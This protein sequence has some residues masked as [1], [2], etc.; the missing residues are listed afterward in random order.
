L[1]RAY[2]I[3]L[4]ELDLKVPMLDPIKCISRVANK[5]NISERTKRRAMD[6]IHDV[7]KSG[8]ATGKDPMGLAASVLYLAC[9]NSGELKSQAAIAEAAGVSEV[10]L[11][12]NQRMILGRQQAAIL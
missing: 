5:A 1:A 6:M 7:I 4:R 8:L 12:K 3:L 10:T 11:R 9:V 2:R